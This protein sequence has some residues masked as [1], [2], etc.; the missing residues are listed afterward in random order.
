M[1]AI[2]QFVNGFFGMFREIAHQHITNEFGMG[3]M[4]VAFLFVAT[5]VMT[6]IAINT[7]NN[8]HD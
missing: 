6:G 4:V 8:P 5:V 2:K 7:P 1:I 3:F